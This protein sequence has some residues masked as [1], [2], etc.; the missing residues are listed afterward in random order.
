MSWVRSH[1]ASCRSAPVPFAHDV[2]DMRHLG[3]VAEF[4]HFGRDER[5]HLVKQIALV[6]LAFS[7]E[8]DQLAVQSIARRASGFR[9]STAADNSEKSHC[10]DAIFVILTTIACIR[11]PA[12]GIDPSPF[13]TRPN[14]AA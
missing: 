13:A 8:I 7:A 10:R 4:V 2:L 6:H 5:E 14:G 1:T 12:S 3:L 9:Q 11:E